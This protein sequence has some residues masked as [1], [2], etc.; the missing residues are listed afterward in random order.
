MRCWSSARNLRREAPVLAHRVR[1]AA[2]R[3]AKIAFLNPARFDYL[4]P[5][6]AYL[7]SPPAQP[8]RGSRGHLL[9]LPR[10]RRARRSTWPRWSPARRPTSAIARLRP[11]SSPGR[12][13][14]S[15]SAR[16]RCAIRRTPTCAPWPPASPPPRAPR[17][18]SLAEGGNAAG[19]YLAGAVP[20]RE[21]A[22]IKSATAGK[23]AREMLAQPQKAYLLF[24]GVE[25]WADALGRRGAE[26]ARRRRLRRGRHAVRRRAR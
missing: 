20:H 19:A 1:K 16:S 10:W 8:A 12:S 18:A 2:K 25:P 3:G 14:P 23:N 6:A 26:G 4:F 7:E 9:G 15:G 11:R 22:G 24:G 5:V 13:A 21:P 17:S